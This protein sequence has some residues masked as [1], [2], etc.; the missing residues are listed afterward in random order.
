MHYIKMI[1]FYLDD[2]EDEETFKNSREYAMIKYYAQKSGL[3]CVKQRS[4]TCG[5]GCKNTFVIAFFDN[6][7]N[8]KKLSYVDR[9]FM[10]GILKSIDEFD[11]IDPYGFASSAHSYIEQ[12]YR[13]VLVDSYSGNATGLKF[14]D[15][16]Y[17]ELQI[18]AD[19]HSN[20]LK[21]A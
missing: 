10:P 7:I 17:E 4:S 11:D 3:I 21:D 5:I 2:N 15:I 8:I 9:C 12:L 18:E 6:N 1:G 20:E 13:C 19:L 16:S 14:A